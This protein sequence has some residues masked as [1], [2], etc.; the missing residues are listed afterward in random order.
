MA[1]MTV[2]QARTMAKQ[3]RELSQ[4]IWQYHIDNQTKL[5]PEQHA[6]L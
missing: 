3:C 4:A 5:S 2:A 6:A 1:K